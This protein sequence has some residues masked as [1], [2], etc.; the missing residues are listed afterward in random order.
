VHVDRDADLRV[1]D[2]GWPPCVADV[3]HTALSETPSTW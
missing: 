2:D 3:V 1:D